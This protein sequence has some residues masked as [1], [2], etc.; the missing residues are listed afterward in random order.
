MDERLLCLVRT[1]IKL[2]REDMT[3]VGFPDTM[4]EE[5]YLLYRILSELVP[6]GEIRFKSSPSKID[7]YILYVERVDDKIRYV[8]EDGRGRVVEEVCLD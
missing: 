5:E 1:M 6:R 3:Q 2:H 8:L 4:T 7:E